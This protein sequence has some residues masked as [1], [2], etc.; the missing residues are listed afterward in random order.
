MDIDKAVAAFGRDDGH[1]PIE[2]MEWALDRWD[3]A[4]PLL[5]ALLANITESRKVSPQDASVAFFAAMLGAEKADG[6]AFAPICAIG[7][8]AEINEEVFGEATTECYA[9]LLVST[10]DADLQPLKA[11]VEDPGADDWARSQAF[12]ALAYLAK[13]G[14]TDPRDA[15]AYLRAS[16]DMLQAGVDP[17]VSY[18]WQEAI[19]ALGLES[20]APMVRE[21]CEKDIIDPALVDFEDFQEALRETLASDDPLAGFSPHEVSPID[22][23]AGYLSGWYGFSEEYRAAKA[24]GEFESDPDEDALD[25]D[26]GPWEAS[27]PAVNPYRDVGRNDPCPC[28]SG[29]KFKKC[30]LTAA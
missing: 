14:R 11:L 9:S 15:E 8:N 12:L 2:A 3:E 1:L 10:F 25:F 7:R 16:F 4:S 23:A 6:R 21:L 18:G 26:D 20:F 28:G 22:D 5:L 24:R 27:E 13:T 29:K 30:C 19:V 17:A